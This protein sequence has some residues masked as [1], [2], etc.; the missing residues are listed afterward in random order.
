MRF[1]RFFLFMMLQLQVHAIASEVIDE[2]AVISQ[3]TENRA[4]KNIALIDK[5]ELDRNVPNVLSDIFLNKPIIGIRFNSR[6]ETVL[7]LRGSDERQAAIFLDGAS[8]G[9]PWD[10]RIDLGLLPVGMISSVNISKGAVPIEY[11]SN[12]MLGA[13]EISSFNDC[14]NRAC[15]FKGEFGSN[16]I[17]S[18]NYTNA[19]T[20]DDYQLTFSGSYRKRDSFSYVERGVIP[21]APVS[22][23]ERDNTDSE[24]ISSWISVGRQLE[25]T[26][27]KLSY[28]LTDAKKGVPPAGHINPS[29]N[30][31]RYWRYPEWKLEQTTFNLIH[32]VNDN[33]FIKMTSWLQKFTQDID[34]FT[35]ATYK[36]L[37]IHKN[38]KDSTKGLRVVLNTDRKK[39]SARFVGNYQGTEHLQQEKEPQ[40]FSASTDLKYSQDLFSLGAEIDIPVS[41]ELQVSL[42]S[43]YDRFQA[44][45]T[46]D[47]NVQPN[48]SDWASNLI[49]EWHPDNNFYVSFGIGDRTRFPTL[50]ELYGVALD[51]FIINPNLKSESAVLADLSLSWQSNE[52]PLSINSTFW[53]TKINDAI[54]KRQILENGK[55]FDQRYNI[56]GSR[57]K[58]FSFD[59]IYSVSDKM[60]IQFNGNLQSHEAEIGQDGLRPPILLRP[61]TQLNLVADYEWYEQVSVRLSLQK[62]SGALDED[63]GGRLLVLNSSNRIDV[64]F[65]VNIND[66]WKMFIVLNNL[67]DSLILPQLGFPDIGREYRIGFERLL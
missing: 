45:G 55:W 22:D 54:S 15:S 27:F 26:S 3:N 21:F 18:Y 39:F 31:T 61:E 10:G 19:K 25:S 17:Q 67:N 28:F 58:G 7:R 66:S 37:K 12:A 63:V 44:P 36:L 50:R 11:G 14:K 49:F 41:E 32:N 46:G 53:S 62:I 6:G 29:K 24:S 23:D 60:Q 40:S 51:K 42:G 35:D 43:S 59:A 5:N 38:D 52:F 13:V 1:R 56:A 64:S 9:I 30:K 57:G 8:L 65:F 33:A 4:M 20:I 16:G 34:Q 48:L 2:L 47:R